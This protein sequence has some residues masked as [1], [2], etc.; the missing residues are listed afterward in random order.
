M[1]GVSGIG[2]IVAPRHTFLRLIS[3][4]SLLFAQYMEKQA[5][6]RHIRVSNKHDLVPVLPPQKIMYGVEPYMH[7]AINVRLIPGKGKNEIKYGNPKTIYSQS[8]W[9]PYYSYQR[10]MVADY[11]KRLK[12]EDFGEHTIEQVYEMHG[13]K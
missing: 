4:T 13:P 6:L 1:K 10:H 9:N 3:T 7:A 8:Y 11:S 5:W 2:R 12:K